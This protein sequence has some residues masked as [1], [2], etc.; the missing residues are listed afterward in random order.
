MPD[1]SS[2]D[3]LSPLVKPYQPP[4]LVSHDISIENEKLQDYL[5]KVREAERLKEELDDL[6]TDYYR[7]SVDAN[8]RKR[9]GIRLSVET[10]D[11]LR[12][13]PIE[14][15]ETLDT[16]YGIEDTLFDLRDE[17]IMQGIFS[18]SE[19][20]Y[21]ARDVLY[22]EIMD[23][24][25]EA[26]ERLPLRVAADHRSE[27]GIDF[28]D[29]RDY[30]NKW[31]LEWA[32]DS[33]IG[34]IMLRSWICFECN[35]DLGSSRWA[36][37]AIDHWDNDS[38]GDMA[39]TLFNAS[40]LDAITGETFNDTGHLGA[41]STSRSGC[42]YDSSLGDFSIEAVSLA[43]TEAG[44]IGTQ[45]GDLEITP[46]KQG[47]DRP[48]NTTPTLK[49]LE[50]KFPVLRAT[51]ALLTAA[52]PLSLG[53]FE[54]YLNRSSRALRSASEPTRR[55]KSTIPDQ[56]NQEVSNFQLQSSLPETDLSTLRSNA[57]KVDSPL[58]FDAIATSTETFDDS[59][60]SG[61]HFLPSSYALLLADLY[62]PLDDVLL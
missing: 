56:G 53:G 21:E 59:L 23:S 11:F 44:T 46:T 8:F 25:C 16:L 50:T 57:V 5:S 33:A 54:T 62:I 55:A 31:L 13:Y 9:H 43:G 37:L 3:E 10:A 2:D 45:R 1:T 6:E 38:A 18:D 51:Q 29:K 7:F 22:E 41:L 20:V 12:N 47:T 61:N 42:L 30:I 34:T 48:A 24:V 39:N 52:K 32:Q 35:E 27:Q 4:E 19:H 14:Y 36:E 40:R 58:F 28:T 15:K 17:C 60:L 26:R 49:L